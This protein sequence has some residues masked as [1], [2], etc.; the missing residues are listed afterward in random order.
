MQRGRCGPLLPRQRA[1]RE[2]VSSHKESLFDRR[3]IAA[4]DGNAVSLL[5]VPDVLQ[6]RLGAFILR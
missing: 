3:L 2:R 4:S 6:P 5:P 1:L